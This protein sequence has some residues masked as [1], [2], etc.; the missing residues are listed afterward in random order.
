MQ[1]TLTLSLGM[2][3]LTGAHTDGKYFAIQVDG[4]SVVVACLRV[5]QCVRVLVSCV[6]VSAVCVCVC[7]CSCRVCVCVSIRVQLHT[8][9]IITIYTD[10]WPGGSISDLSTHTLPDT[11]HTLINNQNRV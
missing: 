11:V 5:R 6:F 10:G 7:V 9:G 4:W 3:H 1:V 8:I 2:Q